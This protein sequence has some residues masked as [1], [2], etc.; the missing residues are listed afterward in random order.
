MAGR[1]TSQF[2]R[3]ATALDVIKGHDLSGR[4]VL[5]TG[6]A[7]G[8]GVETARA[9][10]SAGADLTLAVRDTAKGEAVA[11]DL[12]KATGNDRIAVGALDLGD[13]ASV[14]RFAADFAASHAALHILVNNAGIM[15][16]PEMRTKEG[17]ELQFATNHLGHFLLANLL[18]PLLR[19]GAPARIVS[20]S[21]IGHRR[22][23]VVFDDIH[24]KQ[25]PY[26]KWAAYGQS[27][28]ANALFA[29]GWTR[30]FG[31][32]GITANAVMPGGIM[33]GLQKHMPMEEQKALGW[34]LPD[35][36]INPGMKTPAQG[37]ATSVWAATAKE[38]QGIGGLYLEDCA[39]A[40]PW[41]ED[42]PWS[43]V[44]PHALDAEAAERL[45]SVSEEMTGLA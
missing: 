28:T 12:R 33:T 40:A 2:D 23:P 7:S 31:A 34:I 43:G 29:V 13:Q 3:R 8:I 14:R 32:D 36:S 16:T 1:I 9:F 24:F 39:E 37:A 42:A 21:S 45:W 17:Y 41:K 38:L 15:A 10:A 18:L 27:K 5:V 30:R 26:D 11:A 22:S 19:K 44:L 25:R 4:V 35:G 20:L 6:A